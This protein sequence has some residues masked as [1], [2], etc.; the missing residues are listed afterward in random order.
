M[1]PKYF[2]FVLV[3]FAPVCYDDTERLIYE[4]F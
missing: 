3:F 2:G 1:E 4:V